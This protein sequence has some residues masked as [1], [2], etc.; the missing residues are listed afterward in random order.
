[1]CKIEVGCGTVWLRESFTD[2]QSL[3]AQVAELKAA[4]CTEIFQEKVSGAKSDRK[5]LGV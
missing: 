2:G 4:G 5:L 3:A 1:M